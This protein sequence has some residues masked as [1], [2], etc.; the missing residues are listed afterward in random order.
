MCMSEFREYLESQK[1]TQNGIASR[2]AKIG[3]IES[4]LGTT[5]DN[6]VSNDTRMY[7]ALVA[8]QEHEDPK[9]NPMQ[10]VLRKYYAFKNGREFPHKNDFLSV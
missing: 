2:M 10:N 7:Q 3:K 4:I 5:M 1:L 8:L 6:V 9:H